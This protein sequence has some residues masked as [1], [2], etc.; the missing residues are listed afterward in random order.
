M[1]DALMLQLF[2]QLVHFTACLLVAPYINLPSHLIN[3]LDTNQR[4]SAMRN[5]FMKQ[6]HLPVPHQS[7]KCLEQPGALLR[8]ELGGKWLLSCT[9]REG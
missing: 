2:M 7:Q 1:A 9:D 5:M 6:N 8:A 4:E 3:Q